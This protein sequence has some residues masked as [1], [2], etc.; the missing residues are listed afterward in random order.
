MKPK[1]P[2]AAPRATQETPEEIINDLMQFIR[3]AF[4][5]QNPAWFKDQ[6]FIRERV[7]TW[8]ASWL[9]GRGVTLPP[10][11]YKEILINIFMIIKQNGNTG[12]VQYWPRYLLHCVQ[13]HFKHHG[14]EIYE[15][16]KS[17]RAITDLALSTCRR[18]METNRSADQVAAIAQ[19]HQALTSRKKKAMVQPK[20]QLD[21]L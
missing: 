17:L 12:S 10:G 2:A 4:Y 5:Q 15:E 6:H 11:R 19:V 7:V 18:S 9:D 21:L 3:S 14:D 20:E 8:P 16:G 1:K 13:Q